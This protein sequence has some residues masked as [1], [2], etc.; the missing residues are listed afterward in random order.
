[1]NETYLL[2]TGEHPLDPERD[3]VYEVQV[4]K[5][6]GRKYET[7]WRFTK[8]GQAMFHYDC[9]LVGN[10]FAKRLLCDGKVIRTAMS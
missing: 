9:V 1:M 6:Q 4:R 3:A 10:G 7:R 5:P 2:F 8:H